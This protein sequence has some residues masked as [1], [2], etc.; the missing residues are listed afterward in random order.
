M[1]PCKYEI[2]FE[3]GDVLEFRLDLKRSSEAVQ[4]SLWVLLRYDVTLLQSFSQ[5]AVDIDEVES[6]AASRNVQVL[7]GISNWRRKS[8][9]FMRVKHSLMAGSLENSRDDSI[10]NIIF[11][12]KNRAAAYVVK[13]RSASLT[14]TLVRYFPQ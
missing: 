1:V 5:H 14:T 8:G 13:S 6:C 9:S 3:T 4:A 10:N 11:V 7:E 12:P 2:G